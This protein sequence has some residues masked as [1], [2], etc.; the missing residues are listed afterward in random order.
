[1]ATLVS[2]RR[3]AAYLI[4]L[5]LPALSYAQKDTVTFDHFS[6]EQGLVDYAIWSILQDTM[7]FMWIGTSNALYR[8]DGRTF[9]AFTHDPSDSTSLSDGFIF[10]LEEDHQG[11]TASAVD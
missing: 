1:M 8:Y 7:G 9:K 6:P 2:F 4:L 5:G 10:A 11:M 3:F